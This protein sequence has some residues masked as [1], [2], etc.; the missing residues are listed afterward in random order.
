MGKQWAESADS[1]S[2]T[3]VEGYFRNQ[4]GDLRKFFQYSLSSAKEAE[5]WLQ[6]SRFC[7]I[8][9]SQKTLTPRPESPNFPLLKLK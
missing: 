2:A 1:I 9:S 4:K 7:I 3:M 6:I 8:D 5:H